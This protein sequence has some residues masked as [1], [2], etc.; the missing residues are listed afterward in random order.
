MATVLFFPLP[1]VCMCEGGRGV[2]IM[3]FP[4]P[5]Q[6]SVSAA[7]FLDA[8]LLPPPPPLVS[9]KPMAYLGETIILAIKGGRWGWVEGRLAL[10][11]VLPVLR[12][13]GKRASVCVCV[14]VCL[15]YV[16]R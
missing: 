10:M 9:S 14:C 12:K 16:R 8:H 13:R 15:W 7:V 6:V 5:L 11:V 3:V 4:T 1:L 2:L